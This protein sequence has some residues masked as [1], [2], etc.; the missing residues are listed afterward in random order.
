MHVF[1]CTSCPAVFERPDDLLTR[2]DALFFCEYVGWQVD[3]A[4][5][6][7]GAPGAPIPVLCPIC[8][9]PLVPPDTAPRDPPV[10]RSS[11]HARL[12]LSNP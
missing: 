3:W 10:R 12:P 1:P 9:P 6:Y 4:T 5:F 7:H 11:R 2:Q 8:R